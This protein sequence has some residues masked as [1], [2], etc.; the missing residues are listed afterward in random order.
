MSQLSKS[1][2]KTE[3]L[4]NVNNLLKQRIDAD[5]SSQTFLKDYK[6]DLWEKL[7]KNEKLTDTEF[8]MLSLSIAEYLDLPARIN[9][10]FLIND[11]FLNLDTTKPHTWVEINVNDKT[12]IVDPY[13]ERLTGLQY[14]G[15]EKK[16]DRITMGTWHPEEKY[17][18]I[19]GMLEGDLQRKMDL[20]RLL[21]SK[22][23]T[24]SIGINFLLPE[25]AKAGFNFSANLNIT[26]NTLFAL[27]LD[28]VILNDK[29]Y[30][31]QLKI[32][33]TFLP[34]I[35]PGQ[36][37]KAEIKGI[38]EDNFFNL[39]SKTYQ[40]K[41]DFNNDSF[42]TVTTEGIINLELST[43]TIMGIVSI[44]AGIFIFGI[45]INVRRK[46]KRRWRRARG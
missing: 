44:G 36:T 45:L 20:K 43:Y 38:R 39:G 28:K 33:K 6:N 41:V 35:L 27:P 17:N 14:F 16:L 42:K 11:Y 8:S 18:N 15:I 29:E 21:D 5:I 23:A 22:A 34:L 25:D 19:L 30:T 46:M 1:E 2:D 37:Y 12:I 4:F 10:G 7:S 13:L 9:Y 3:Q 26:N 40:I 32:N 24:S 31:N